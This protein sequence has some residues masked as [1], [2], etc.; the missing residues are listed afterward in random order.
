MIILSFDVGVKNLALCLINYDNACVTI[1]DW[2][3]I[4]LCNDDKNTTYVQCMQHRK[5]VQCYKPAKFVYKNQKK[6]VCF[7]LFF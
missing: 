2:S 7:N 1:D 5:N 4:D 3:V 6:I